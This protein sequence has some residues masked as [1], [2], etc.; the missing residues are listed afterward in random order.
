MDQ[1]WTPQEA[2]QYL[3]ISYRQFLK[4]T[5]TDPTFPAC[6]IG[7]QWRIDPDELKRWVSEQQTPKQTVI[8]VP[9]V[10]RKR[11]RPANRKTAKTTAKPLGGWQLTLPE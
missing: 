2:C 3:K 5:A 6:K 7:G 4:F 11:G 8:V 1:L 10:S 9:I